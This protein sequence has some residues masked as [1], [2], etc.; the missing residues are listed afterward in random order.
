M[1]NAKKDLRRVL[2]LAKLGQVIWISFAILREKF[3]ATGSIYNLEQVNYSERGSRVE[4]IVDG[5]PKPQTV[6]FSGVDC[7]SEIYY[8][9]EEGLRYINDSRLD[10]SR[11]KFVLHDLDKIPKTMKNPMQFGRN[12]KEPDNF[13][14]FQKY[15]I[16]EHR[17]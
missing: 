7:F 4:I 16:K 15:A 1:Y 17:Y 11:Q 12:L 6:I 8:F 2:R 10:R 9:T 5:V 3:L 13:V 14:Y